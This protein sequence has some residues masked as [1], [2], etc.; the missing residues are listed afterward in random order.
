M[1][2]SPMPVSALLYVGESLLSFP[3]AIQRSPC[4][5]LLE[6]LGGRLDFAA[7]VVA[8]AGPLIKTVGSLTPRRAARGS[9]WERP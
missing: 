4:L 6:V 8:T 2:P 7:T 9:W 5:R 3:A 1:V